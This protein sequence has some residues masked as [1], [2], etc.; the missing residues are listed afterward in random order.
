[1]T[2]DTPIVTSN[3]PPLLSSFLYPFSFVAASRRVHSCRT[4]QDQTFSSDFND[5]LVF[6][7]E[8]HPDYPNIGMPDPNYIQTTMFDE[9]L[10]KAFHEVTV[11]AFP[12]ALAHVGG[13][14][15]TFAS[16]SLGYHSVIWEE[17][18]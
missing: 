2:S 9:R 6:H 5:E 4:E 8:Q 16:V 10:P 7:M 11:K 13:L 3:T 15:S 1:M 18:E 14:M 17:L 12:E